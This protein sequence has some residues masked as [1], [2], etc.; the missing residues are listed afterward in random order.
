VLEEFYRTGDK[1]KEL[2]LS[3]SPFCDR[4]R[5]TA[6]QCQVG[7]IDFVVRPIFDKLAKLLPAVGESFMACVGPNREHYVSVKNREEQRRSLAAAAAAAATPVRKPARGGYFE[8][9]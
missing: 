7:F 9:P 3:I 4:T 2:G 5:P 8:R 6:G 1:E